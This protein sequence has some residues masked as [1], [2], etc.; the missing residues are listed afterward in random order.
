MEGKS[1]TS[2]EVGNEGHPLPFNVSR[3]VVAGLRSA[4]LDGCRYISH[5]PELPTVPVVTW[6]DTHLS[7]NSSSDTMAAASFPLPPIAGGGCGSRF[8]SHRWIWGCWSS[9]SFWQCSRRWKCGV[10]MIYYPLLL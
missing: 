6:K 5:R 4:A 7:F 2:D 3:D 1:Q 8:E 9:G 10:K